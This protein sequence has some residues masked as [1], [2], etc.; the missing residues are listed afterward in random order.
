ME[1]LLEHAK[2]ISQSLFKLDTFP[3]FFSA[4]QQTIWNVDE[5][6]AI[7]TIDNMTQ[8]PFRLCL[9]FCLQTMNTVRINKLVSVNEADELH[10]KMEVFS[11]LLW[12]PFHSVSKCRRKQ[13]KQ[14]ATVSINTWMIKT[15]QTKSHISLAFCCPFL[16][17]V[18]WPFSR[19]PFALHSTRLAYY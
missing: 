13:Q 7:L 4:N 18:T 17:C 5:S 14:Q 10:L 9:S 19:I 3:F 8:T 2:T 15:S 11:H 16:T 1:K 6:K 12:I